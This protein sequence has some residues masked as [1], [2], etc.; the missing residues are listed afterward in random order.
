MEIER[1]VQTPSKRYF[2]EDSFRDIC[3]TPRSHCLIGRFGSEPVKVDYQFSFQRL[4]VGSIS[5]KTMN[6]QWQERFFVLTPIRLLYYANPTQSELKGCFN[7]AGLIEHKL[8]LSA[9]FPQIR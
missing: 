2:A 9:S 6:S 5:K 1:P 8:D 4:K 3:F 7:L